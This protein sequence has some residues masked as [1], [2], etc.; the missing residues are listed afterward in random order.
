[1]KKKEVLY[2]LAEI[3]ERTFQH[4]KF[5]KEIEKIISGKTGVEGAIFQD[6]FTQLKM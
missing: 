6:I 1:M 5:G 4:E 3:V 2:L